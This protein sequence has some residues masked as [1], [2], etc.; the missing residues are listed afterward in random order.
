MNRALEAALGEPIGRWQ[1]AEGPTTDV[2]VSS[3]VRL[4]RNV[5]D[6]PFPPRMEAAHAEALWGRVEQGSAAMPAEIGP[7]TLVRLAELAPLDRQ[8]LVE[9]HLISPQHAQQGRGGLLL[10]ADEQLSAMVLEEDHLRLQVLFPGLQLT[11]AWDLGRRFDDALEQS[12]DWAFSPEL[13][14]L[15]TC[16]TNVGTGLRASAMLHLPALCWT[17]GIAPLLAG[18]G[19]VGVVARGLYGEGSAAGGNLFQVSN[20]TTLGQGEPDLVGHLEAVAREIVARERSAREALLAQRRPA[21]ED[22]V[23]RAYGLLS[24][25]RLLSSAEA[26]QL[27]SDVRLG[28][29]LQVLPPLRADR[30]AELLVL[31]RSGF[32]QRRGGEVPA[33]GRDARRAEMVRRTL[34]ASLVAAATPPDP[35]PAPAGRSVRGPAPE[36]A[37]GS[38]RAKQGQEDA[39][40]AGIRAEG[41]GTA[42]ASLR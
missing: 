26:L 10:R 32:L 35:G 13:G 3:R 9:K 27:L 1:R 33:S 42:G 16:P 28:G 23:W 30:W 22:R 14:Y 8:V 36:A 12:I 24:S 34:A 2:A 19:K 20:Q 21:L 38:G 39:A 15:S 5:A 11:A 17:G 29:D 31:T 18:L 25:A 40:D 37:P 41:D 4:A 6:L 7:L